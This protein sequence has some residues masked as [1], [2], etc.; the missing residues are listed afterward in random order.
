MPDVKSLSTSGDQGAREEAVPATQPVSDVEMEDLSKTEP[1]P[2]NTEVNADVSNTEDQ[3]TEAALTPIPVPDKDPPVG[4]SATSKARGKAP[5]SGDDDHELTIDP[6]DP[7]SNPAESGDLAVDIMLLLT[8]GARHPFRI[9]E[10]YLSKRN[11]TVTG[12]TEDG[13]MDPFSITVYTLKELILR[14]WRKEWDHPPRE[15]SAIRLIHFGKMLEDR[16]QLNHYHFS[17]QR[18]VVHMTIKPQDLIDEEEAAKKVKDAGSHRG[19][20]GCCVIL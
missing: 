5:A 6:V 15:P 16:N 13:K 10:K 11:V 4:E 2:T 17:V 12:K 1:K 20:S 18:N 14:D 3:D 19:R 9:D 7:A 8:S